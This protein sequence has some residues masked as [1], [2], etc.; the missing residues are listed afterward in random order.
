M[1]VGVFWTG[2]R[3]HAQTYS[4]V[5]HQK[6]WKKQDR[7]SD[8]L[9]TVLCDN[10]DAYYSHIKKRGEKK[11]NVVNTF[12]KL[13]KRI[14]PTVNSEVPFI[15]VLLSISPSL[16]FSLSSSQFERKREIHLLLLFPFLF[17][18]SLRFV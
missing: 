13:P 9:V 7:S 3:T 17:P 16:S 15:T 4:T 14:M 10:L 8:C 12:Q 11:K 1:V 18:C 6:L 2:A 5:I